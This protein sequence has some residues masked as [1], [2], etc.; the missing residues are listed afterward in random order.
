MA[1]KTNTS[2]KKT[3]TTLNSEGGWT[4]SSEKKILSYDGVSNRSEVYG[5]GKTKFYDQFSRIGFLDP[6]NTLTGAREYLFFTKPDLNLF[7]KYNH[8]E[9]QNRNYSETKT[10]GTADK[11]D[12]KVRG[13][14]WTGH[15]VTTTSE[16]NPDLANYPFFIDLKEKYPKI[17]E[18]LQLS[19]NNG[20]PFMKMLSNSVKN[21]LDLPDISTRQVDT[22]QTVYG[23]SIQ[24]E[25]DDLSSDEGVSFDLE[26]EDTRNIE[27]Y[28][29]FKTW[30]EY[31]RKKSFGLVEP[32]WNTYR[33]Q[34][35]LHDQIAIFKFI[36]AEDGE[37]IIHYS[38]LYGCR[39]QGVPRSTFSDL[40]SNLP[41]RFNVNWRAEFVED[42]EPM[43]LVDFNKLSQNRSGKEIEVFDSKSMRSNPEMADFARIAVV[44]DSKNMSFKTPET[45]VYKLK[46]FKEK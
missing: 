4:D 18:Q 26:F 45:K 5:T 30:H 7:S 44:T 28:M 3:N 32:V 17:G 41:I 9:T 43:I 14:K 34:K 33:F 2:S 1:K 6:Y 20:D 36:V 27:V 29:L 39:P 25:A 40:G 19:L 15:A 24:Y 35:I 37:T 11:L 8:K 38:K 22:A 23:T 16:L 46:W 21:T 13:A 42:M 10:Q 12:G 31:L